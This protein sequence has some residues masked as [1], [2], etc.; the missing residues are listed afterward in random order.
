MLPL[1]SSQYFIVKKIS[2]HLSIDVV[3]FIMSTLRAM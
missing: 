2:V 3:I 1:M